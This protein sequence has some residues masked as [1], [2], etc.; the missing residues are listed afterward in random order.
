MSE[1]SLVCWKCGAP[2]AELPLP[3][4]R[5]AECAACRAELHV[6]RMCE[7]Y[8]PGVANACREPVA[9]PVR[10]KTRANFCGYFQIRSNA[11]RPPEAERA[12]TARDRLAE[13]FGEAGGE[14]ED[15]QEGS[16]AQSESEAAQRR[17]ERM[18]RG[19]S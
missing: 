8:D 12:R 2:L 14:S 11:Y 16:G 5:Y 4:S 1:P 17:L 15:G 19:E 3:L 13:L 6:C 10:D 7:F 18:L 9:D